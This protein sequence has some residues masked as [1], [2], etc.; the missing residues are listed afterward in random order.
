MY[1]SE[2]ILV[3]YYRR[4]L[5]FCK[6]LFVP[7]SYFEENQAVFGNI[8]ERK[9]KPGCGFG[10]KVSPS[11][12]GQTIPLFSAV[13]SI[14]AVSEEGREASRQAHLG[15]LSTEFTHGDALHAPPPLPVSQDVAATT[16]PIRCLHI[17]ATLT[18][19]FK[20]V[21]TIRGSQV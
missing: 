15:F 6:Q 12:C 11:T 16:H 9:K 21:R 7:H 8:G 1:F 4:H 5:S 14:N 3:R 18:S 2:T 20:P 17:L 19:I 13:K 10:C